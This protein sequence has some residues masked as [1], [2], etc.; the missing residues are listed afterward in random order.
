VRFLFLDRITKIE[1]GKSI[2]AI[3]TFALAEEFH[4]KHF[5]K[6]PL[7]PGVVF[8]ESMAQVL[9]W[10]INYSHDFKLL[11]IMSLLAEVKVDAHLRP[12]FEARVRAEIISTSSGDSIG[13]AWVEIQGGDRVASIERVIYTH[14]QDV[15]PKELVRWFRYCSGSE[16]PDHNAGGMS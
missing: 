10:L 13:R 14:L 9:G 5:S 11:A 3:K 12:G 15:D 8:I 4:R 1:K 16:D 2:E 6:I 7:V